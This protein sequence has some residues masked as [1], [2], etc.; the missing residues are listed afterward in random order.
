MTSIWLCSACGRPNDR[1][2]CEFIDLFLFAVR[3]RARLQQALT[4]Y[5]WHL[6]DGIANWY[7]VM[8]DA[9]RECRDAWEEAA[10]RERFCATPVIEPIRIPPMSDEMRAALARA[11]KATGFG[12]E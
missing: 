6:N 10:D 11:W 1:C 8:S 12:R 7:A 2:R 5:P 9:E 4:G 3:K